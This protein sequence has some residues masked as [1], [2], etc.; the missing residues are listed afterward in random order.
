MINKFKK[1]LLLVRI[2]INRIALAYDAAHHT[3]KKIRQLLETSDSISIIFASTPSQKEFLEALAAQPN[4]DWNR[5]TAF[6]MAEYIGLPDDAAQSFGNFLKNHLFYKVPFKAVHY[7]NGNAADLEQECKRY[8]GL[9][10][11]YKPKIVCMGIGENTHIAFN[12]PHVPDLDETKTVKMVKLDEQ[13]RR[14]QVSDGCFTSLNQVPTRALT[15]TISALF[16]PEV[17]F[18]MVPDRDKS[19]AVYHTLTEN[20]CAKYPSTVLRQHPNSILFLDKESAMLI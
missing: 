9:L 6:H 14:Q 4:I 10:T 13:C 12:D 7:L 17:V 3:A 20:I 1:D 19:Q 8:A 18:C 15:L 16:S 11:E 2:Y 5:I